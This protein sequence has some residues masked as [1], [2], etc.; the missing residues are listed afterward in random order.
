MVFFAFVF[1]PSVLVSAEVLNN[2]TVVTVKV[3]YNSQLNS[4]SVTAGEKFGVVASTVTVNNSF[5]V[6]GWD[7]V[8]ATSDEIFLQSSNKSESARRLRLAYQAAGY[9]EGYITQKSILD[10]LKNTFWGSGGL[11]RLLDLSPSTVEWVKKH[12]SLM[13]SEINSK[14][15]YNQQLGNMFALVDGIV[16]GYNDRVK[17]RSEFLNRTWLFYLNL[18]AEIGDI[19]TAVKP[20]KDVEKLRPVFPK[21]LFDLHCSALVKMTKEDIYF[22]HVTWNSFNS[23]LRQYKTYKMGSSF[24]T[25]SS[26][27]G[28]VHSI[29]DWYMTD[30]KLAVME[31]TNGVYN[32]SLFKNYLSPKSVSAFLRVMIAN[33]LATDAP[34][35]VKY[36]SRNNSGTY[37]NQWMIFNM[38]AVESP[39]KPLPP[40]TFF[41]AEQLPG[42]TAPLGVTSADMTDH[43]NKHG[44]WASY[45]IPYFKSVY[46][47]SGYTAQVNK[48]GDFFSYDNS[49]RAK[50]FAR[51][52]HKVV[53]LQST[54]KLMRYN[55]YKVDNLS[56]ITNCKEATGGKCDPPYS[57]M[58]AIS[59]RG[60]LNPEGG[61]DK[62]GSLYGYLSHCNHGGTDAK[63]ATW[64]GMTQ[65]PEYYTAHVVCGPTS[66]QQPVFVWD[67]TT[68]KNMPPFYGI[69]HKY[70]YSFV[71]YVT[72]VI[73]TQPKTE[74][75][76][77]WIGIGIGIAAGTLV[78]VA[79]IIFVTYIRRHE[80]TA[81]EEVMLF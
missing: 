81:N 23:M 51:D 26:Y 7:V 47:I 30:K 35:W 54:K 46:N 65:N 31:T 43:L 39:E 2:G 32:T 60:D 52:H 66:D 67:N 75:L 10:T 50:I 45:N 74:I 72:Y 68:F 80:R 76:S 19:F 78:L 3:R 40:N 11:Q 5:P 4:F 14:D 44:Y 15:E 71:E 27:P 63:I 58:L 17:N 57:A 70:N 48:Y 24:V 53:D 34:S 28:L 36:F 1:T 38:G 77:K 64:T 56:R 20:K 8:T 6:T 33:F 73:S 16:A 12:I 62:Y 37:N 13:E 9:G 49:V 79:I 18:Q 59:S 69:P 29:D 25:M 41:V 22:S 21:F 55:N 42:T 61:K